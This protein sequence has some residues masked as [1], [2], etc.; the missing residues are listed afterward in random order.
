MSEPTNTPKRHHIEVDKKTAN[1]FR[2]IRK[3]L[4]NP[5][6]IVLASAALQRVIEQVNAGELVME[7]G[8]LKPTQP[9]GA[10]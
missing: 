5:K 8:T 9:G 10:N 1:G 7:N 4:G 2:R 3:G 6:N